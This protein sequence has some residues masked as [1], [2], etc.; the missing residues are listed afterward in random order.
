MDPSVAL[1]FAVAAFRRYD[2]TTDAARYLLQFE[3]TAEK[4][5][6]DEKWRIRDLD[7]FLDGAAK[8]W[9]ATKSES[10]EVKVDAGDDPKILWKEVTT[11]MGEFFSKETQKEEARRLLREVRFK[12]GDDPLLYVTHR[13]RYLSLAEP[14]LDEKD[15]VSR[16]IEGLPE[17]LR[18]SIMYARSTTV[19][20]FTDN[21]RDLL[22]HSYLGKALRRKP[23]DPNTMTTPNFPKI[24]PFMPKSHFAPVPQSQQ[25]FG[26]ANH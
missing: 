5:K 1:S 20:L 3:E 17:E 11:E 4:L 9:W 18:L 19:V 26:V 24:Q 6:K 13:C 21:L 23:F 7:R 12:V 25:P 2:G 16:L 10:Y 15:K 8:F 22:N 14:H